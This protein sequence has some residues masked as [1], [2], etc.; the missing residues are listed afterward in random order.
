MSELSEILQN[1][2]AAAAYETAWLAYE[3]ARELPRER[4]P[5]RAVAPDG[6]NEDRLHEVCPA[7]TE[8][9]SYV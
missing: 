9:R 1:L 5:A 4:R 2:D 3:A 6:L 7:A 8:G